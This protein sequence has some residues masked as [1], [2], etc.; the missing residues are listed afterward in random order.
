MSIWWMVILCLGTPLEV[1]LSQRYLYSTF[2]STADGP[3]CFSEEKYGVNF[4]NKFKYEGVN[5]RNHLITNYTVMTQSLKTLPNI[6]IE[7]IVVS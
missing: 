4:P 7:K 2:K 1:K 3:K 5:Y 6:W